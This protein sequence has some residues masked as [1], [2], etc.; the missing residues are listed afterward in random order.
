MCS[1]VP[2]LLNGQSFLQGETKNVNNPVFKLLACKYR[3]QSKR[4]TVGWGDKTAVVICVKM[5]LNI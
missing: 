1:K 2:V 3:C 4:K 5:Y